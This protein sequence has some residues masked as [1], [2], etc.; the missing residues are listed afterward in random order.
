MA[1]KRPENNLIWRGPDPLRALLV[2]IGS[3]SEDPGNVNNHDARS[4]EEIAG[5]YSRF[6]QQ[7]PVVSAPDGV[8]RAGNGQLIA[9]R[10]LGWT[11]LA[12]IVSDLADG[13]L[14]AFALADNRVAQHA[15]FDFQKLAAKLREFEAAG[16]ATEGM[17][18]TG[19]ELEPLLAADWSPPAVEPLESRA[20]PAGPEGDGAGGGDSSSLFMSLTAD[21]NRA[22]TEASE[23]LSEEEGDAYDSPG[24]ALERICRIYL[25]SP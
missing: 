4:I 13:E 19:Y 2:P 14:E 16:T 1:R 18:W 24:A 10:G 7:K 20:D 5:A 25:D 12:V 21:Q 17:G 9:A 22:L 11:H 3:L 23:R 15:Q 6:G 8:V